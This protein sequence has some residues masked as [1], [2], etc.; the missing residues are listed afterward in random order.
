MPSK[1]FK[2]DASYTSLIFGDYGNDYHSNSL[3]APGGA[4]SCC[5]VG[6]LAGPAR[7][8]HRHIHNDDIKRRKFIQAIAQT[9]ISVANGLRLAVV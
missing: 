5:V 9:S 1:G 7:R 4:A 6:I 8:I 2:L 3:V